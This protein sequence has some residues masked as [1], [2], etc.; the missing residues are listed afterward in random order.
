MIT[1]LEACIHTNPLG[2]SGTNPICTRV[3]VEPHPVR[4]DGSMARIATVPYRASGRWKVVS[5]LSSTNLGTVPG[6]HTPISALCICK[7]HC[8]HALAS[9]QPGIGYGIQPMILLRHRRCEE[10]SITHADDAAFDGSDPPRQ[11][12]TKDR[13]NPGTRRSMRLA[14]CGAHPMVRAC[15]AGTG[16]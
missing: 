4:R 2:F 8:T 16:D 5:C 6:C 7:S 10:L 3:V 15:N 9:L 14:T 12:Y 13:H 1:R 11:S